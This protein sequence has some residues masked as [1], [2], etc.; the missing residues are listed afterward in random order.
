VLLWNI[1][2]Q[3][4]IQS[5]VESRESGSRESADERAIGFRFPGREVEARSANGTSASSRV[6]RSK[7][8]R[9]GVSFNPI[10]RHRC[11]GDLRF[12]ICYLLVV[13]CCLLYAMYRMLPP[14]RPILHCSLF[15]IHY[16]LSIIPYTR[17]S[18]RCSPSGRTTAM[19][20]PGEITPLLRTI[21]MIPALRTRFPSASRSSVAAISP[22]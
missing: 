21:A 3:P 17:S 15:I 9:W 19:G 18:A 22:G 4:G 12:A 1:G 2:F 10:I 7:E 13:D 6:E 16:S 20:S 8:A 14:R 5:R 11:R